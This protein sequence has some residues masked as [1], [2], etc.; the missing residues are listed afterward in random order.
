MRDLN[1]SVRGMGMSVILVRFNAVFARESAFS[2]PL[3]PTWLGTHS[4]TNLVGYLE[5]R[6]RILLIM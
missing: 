4:R 5:K 2:L 3:I 1:A 6:V